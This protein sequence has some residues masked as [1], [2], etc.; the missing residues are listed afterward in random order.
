MRCRLSSPTATATS[1]AVR[2]SVA[3]AARARLRSSSKAI[4]GTVAARRTTR[5]GT[6]SCSAGLASAIAAREGRLGYNVKLLL[7]TGEE[8]GSPGLHDVCRLRRAD[9][10]ADALIASD[11]PRLSADRPTLFLGSRG[12][13]RFHALAS[14]ARGP[15]HHSGT[16][17]ASWPIP[18]RCSR[19][20]SRHDTWP[21]R[22]DR[23]DLRSPPLPKSCAA[24]S[25]ES[26]SAATPGIRRSTGPGRERV[27]RPPSA[28][29]A[30]TRSKCS[31]SRPQS[32]QPGERDSAARHRPIAS[33]C[34]SSSEPTA[35]LAES[36]SDATSRHRG[37]R[38]WK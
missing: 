14:P 28:S 19:M 9:L 18:Q 8:V 24:R 22:N 31:P 34:A 25:P 15:G 11:G 7:E 13:V 32:G 23:V 30:P 10:S 5:A 12:C 36:T 21:A 37:I 2:R 17:A 38:G 6:A 1:C 4:A 35:T 26:P 27:S 16:G 3:C 33:S 29:S 20:G